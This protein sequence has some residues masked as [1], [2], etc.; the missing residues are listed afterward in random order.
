MFETDY[1]H[2]QCLYPNVREKIAETLGR[3]DTATQRK[4][5]FENAAKLY[6]ITIN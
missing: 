1:P 2:P 6:G 3:Y 4:V 5:M